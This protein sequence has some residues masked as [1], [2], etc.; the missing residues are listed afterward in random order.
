MVAIWFPG[1]YI[2]ELAIP[3][4]TLADFWILGIHIV[5]GWPKI[6]IL[7]KKTIW[8]SLKIWDSDWVTAPIIQV[9]GGVAKT[10]WDLCGSILDDW[11]ADFYKRRGRE[12]E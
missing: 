7:K 9:V 2:P 12:K 6:V 8:D 4:V 10:V 1:M 11:A 5:I 3:A